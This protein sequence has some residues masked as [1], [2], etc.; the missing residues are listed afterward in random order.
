MAQVKAEHQKPCGLMQPLEIPK[1]K[2]EHITMGTSKEV[3]AR[4][5]VPISI[6]SDRDVRF[7]S[8]FWRKFHE[9]MG[10][11]LNLSTA[12]H[13]QT[14]GQSERTIQTLEDMLRACIIDFG[15]TWDLHLPLVEFSYNNS[16]HAS[17]QMPPYEMLYGRRCRTPS[18]WLEPGEKQFAGPEIVQMTA[19]KVNIAKDALRV[20][21]ER[22][23]SYAD[24]KRRPFDFKEGEM[25]MLKVSPWKGIIRFGKRGKLSPRF[26]GPFKILEKVNEQA[27]RLNLPPELDGIHSTFH[28]CYLRKCLA[29]E[30]SV[31]PLEDV[32]IDPKKRIIDEPIEILGRKQKKLRNKVI[33]LVLVKWKHTRGESMT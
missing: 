3:V 7:T 11:R 21:R 22:Q 13:P 32:S 29:N 9:E 2:W 10:T 25:V 23:K 16:Y 17:I 27:Y 19:E 30:T 12:Y 14:D 20:A 18:C 26:I 5:G 28:V 6:V 15:G 31:I 4:H 24:K 1:W 8:R 33:D